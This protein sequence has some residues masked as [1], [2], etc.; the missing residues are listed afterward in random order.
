MWV[1][2]LDGFYSA[3]AHRSEPNTIIVRCRDLGD[4]ERLRNALFLSHRFAA[5]VH[6]TPEADYAYRLFV[7]RTMWTHY[8]S[9]QANSIDYPNFKDAVADRQG[10]E[11]ADIYH[12][13]WHVMWE[14]QRD[15]DDRIDAAHERQPG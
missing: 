12:D 2:T 3:V 1:F 14:F 4:A 9:G 13:V 15:N 8:L 10:L 11:R 5:E 7:S 6:H